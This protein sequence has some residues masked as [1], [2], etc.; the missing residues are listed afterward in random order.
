M[1]WENRDVNVVEQANIPKLSKLDDI[2]SPLRPFESFFHDVLVDIVVAY[3]KF[4]S[5]REK[6]GTSF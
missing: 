1:K 3:T 2:G 6:A 4:Y 5:H